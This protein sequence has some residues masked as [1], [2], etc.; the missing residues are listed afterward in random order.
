MWPF[1]PND[2]APVFVNQDEYI[3]TTTYA[4][5]PLQGTDRIKYLAHTL[6][7]SKSR[8]KYR[9]DWTGYCPSD[10]EASPS[11]IACVNKQIELQSKK[12]TKNDYTDDPFETE[13][14]IGEKLVAI[15]HT[16]KFEDAE[17]SGLGHNAIGIFSEKIEHEFSIKDNNIIYVKSEFG[18]EQNIILGNIKSFDK[19]QK[20][21]KT[22]LI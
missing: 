19:I 2:W 20:N 9:I 10:R 21:L 1:K 8:D 17:V 12:C 6:Y 14:S 18:P 5:V 22:I 3:V 13:Y 16:L 7:Y 15:F 11:Y 4:G